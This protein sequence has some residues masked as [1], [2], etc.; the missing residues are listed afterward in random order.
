MKQA[1]PPTPPTLQA[2]GSRVLLRPIT[3]QD[4]KE[5]VALHRASRAHFG[6]WTPPTLSV[7]EF[8]KNYKQW[9]RTGSLR[10]VVC[11]KQDGRMIG[12][13]A[14]SQ[15]V[16]GRLRSAYMGYSVGAAYAGQGYMQEALQLA[17]R[18]VFRTLKLNRVEAN[19]QPGNRPSIALA[20]RLGFSM[21]GYSRRYLKLANGW[22][23]HQRWTLLAS[24]WK[25]TRKTRPTSS[26]NLDGIEIRDLGLH[27]IA[28][29]AVLRHQISLQGDFMLPEPGEVVAEKESFAG[30][31]AKTLA[32]PL[33]KRI[34]ALDRGRVVGFV[35]GTRGERQRNQHS[36]HVGIGLLD[37]YAGRGIGRRLMDEIEAWARETGA[38]RLDLRVMVHNKRAVALYLRC[39]YA[40]EGR[41]RGEF[42]IDGKLV[43]AYFMGKILE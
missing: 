28:A 9:T 18:H 5:L 22:R 37:A 1:A 38:R 29:F 20:Q 21:E 40:I 17:L 10:F 33:I 27:D 12:D 36:V 16:L 35:S 31:I 42:L 26:Q 7:A 6:S 2:R 15:I 32:D 13:V 41:T 4:A 24:D 14:F 11:L 34:L 19:I 3:L 25:P 8:R 43:D 30:R 23:D 39:G